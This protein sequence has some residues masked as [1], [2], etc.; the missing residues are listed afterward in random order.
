MPNFDESHVMPINIALFCG[1]TRAYL[2]DDILKAKERMR[3]IAVGTKFFFESNQLQVVQIY[4]V[5]KIVV[6]KKWEITS[7]LP[8]RDIRLNNDSIRLP[9]CGESMCSRW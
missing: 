5:R 3:E 7:R 4:C 8:V 6:W 1:E 9:L 2:V